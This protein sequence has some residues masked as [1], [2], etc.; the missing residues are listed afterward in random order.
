MTFTR[1]RL[2]PLRDD[3]AATTAA[4]AAAAARAAAPGPDLLKG[5]DTLDESGIDGAA[6]PS[7]GPAPDIPGAAAAFGLKESN[8]AEEGRN[9]KL[10]AR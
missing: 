10:A 4:A 1:A 8:V 6:S 2:L 3:E 9:E 7:L 5:R